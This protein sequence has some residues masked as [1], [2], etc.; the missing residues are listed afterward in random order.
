MDKMAK[1]YKASKIIT[2][3][4]DFPEVTHVA[5]SEGKILALGSL[6]DLAYLNLPVDDCFAGKVLTPGFVEGHGHAIAGESWRYTYLGYDQQMDPKGKAWPGIINQQQALIRLSTAQAQLGVED[7]PLIG[8][9]YDP[10]FWQDK[11]QVLD[12]NALDSISQTRPIM[13]MHASGHVLNVN[14][15]LLAMA[16]LDERLEIEG[17]IKDSQGRLTGELRDLASQ[18][19]VLKAIGNPLIGKVDPQILDAYAQLAVN[20][21]VTTASELYAS[22]DPLSMRSYSDAANR[23][24]YPIRLYAAQNAETLSVEDALLRL[25]EGKALSNDK[26]HLGSCKLIVDGSIQS[27]TARL[28]WPGYLN[29]AANGAWKQ[30]PQRMEQMIREYHIAGIQLHIHVNGDQ[31]TELVLGILEKV[32]KE[33]PWPDHRHTLQHCQMA[34]EAQYRKMAALGVC[35][36]LFSNHLY[37]WGDQH[38]TITVGSNKAARM[39]AAASALKHGVNLAIHSDTPVTPLN[40]LFSAWCAVTRTSRSGKVNGENQKINITQALHAMTLGA[41]YTLKLDHLVGSIE[42][43]KFADFAVLEQDPLTVASQQLKD[44]KV[45]GTVLA[46]IPYPAASNSYDSVQNVVQEAM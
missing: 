46:G 3:S 26:L 6:E 24:D 2:L 41:A 29:G 10:I 9:H 27:F 19:A 22:L 5:V 1:I 45:W 40:P 13:V 31:A 4:P 12:R 37:Y 25:E 11:Q 20:A 39:N 23:D 21:G 38:S 42:V 33:H 44:I 35:V 30:P 18:F 28:E 17:L 7:I 32:L 43:G 16:N 14:S 8:W 36:N 15:A 34:S